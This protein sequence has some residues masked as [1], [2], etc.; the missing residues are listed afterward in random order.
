M[1]FDLDIENIKE[2]SYC[3]QEKHLSQFVKRKDN[4]DGYDSRC[5]SCLKERHSLVKKLKKTAP[6]ISL[7]CDCC[8]KPNVTKK[9][10]KKFSFCLDHDVET[11]KFRGWLCSKCNTGI[12][13]LG[14]NI[15][16]LMKA[17]KYL[18]RSSQ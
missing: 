15:E 6:P 17:I 2:C 18:K 13:S 7:L 1:I 12:G 16:G 5:K 3:N 11:N 8:G 4:Y 10:R 9:G 14:D